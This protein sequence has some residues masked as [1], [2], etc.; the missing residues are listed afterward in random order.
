MKKIT[1]KKTMRPKLEAPI[2]AAIQPLTLRFNSEEQ[3][4]VVDKINEIIAKV[5]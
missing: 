1:P 2:L 3:N 4:I 5:N